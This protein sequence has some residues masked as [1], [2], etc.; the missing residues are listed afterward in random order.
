[1]L[2]LLA[3]LVTL[4]MPKSMQKISFTH[5]YTRA[6]ATTDRKTTKVNNNWF[7][8]NPKIILKLIAL[9]SLPRVAY[10]EVKFCPCTAYVHTKTTPTKY[11]VCDIGKIGILG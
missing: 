10:Y 9:V 4:K 6:L 1:M 8:F 7:N 11:F 2:E 5:T 3:M